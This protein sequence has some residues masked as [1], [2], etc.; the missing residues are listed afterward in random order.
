MTRDELLK[1]MRQAHA[2]CLSALGDIPD[3]VMAT[4]RVTDRWTLKDLLGHLAM[5]EQVA[6]QF[7]AEYKRDG[8]PQPLGL[9]DDAAIDAHNERQV[10]LRRDWPLARVRAEFD[11]AHRDLLAAVASLSDDDLR[12]SLPG[13]WQGATLENLIAWNSHEHLAEHREQIRRARGG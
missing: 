3:D 8:A 4:R 12:Q 2:D 1:A 10:A 13:A 11:V 9:Q 5:W 7:I 6:T